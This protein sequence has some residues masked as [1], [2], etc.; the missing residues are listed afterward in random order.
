M[1]AIKIW[2]WVG[3]KAFWEAAALIVCWRT[4]SRRLK[5]ADKLLGGERGDP[6]KPKEHCAEPR[7]MPIWV[8]SK[9]IVVGTGIAFSAHDTLV[10]GIKQ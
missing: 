5:V 10:A 3:S 4:K 6:I 7:N 1:A 8:I 9:G 2:R